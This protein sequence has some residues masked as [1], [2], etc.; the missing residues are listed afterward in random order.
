M[1]NF[2]YSVFIILVFFS[3]S[4]QPKI[5][6]PDITNYLI[7]LEPIIDSINTK[8]DIKYFTINEEN[9][10]LRIRIM[11]KENKLFGDTI[12][13]FGWRKNNQIYINYEKGD[14]QELKKLVDFVIDICLKNIYLSNI[15]NGP[16]ASSFSI[17][18]KNHIYTL[19]NE[20]VCSI[21]K[22]TA[23]FVGEVYYKDSIR[24]IYKY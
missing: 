13:V 19:R 16:F 12:C 15:T 14:N 24:V 18:Y 20:R 6:I 11:D 1:V 3:C 10:T 22:N 21:K 23:N 7:G 5:N 8:Y 17:N 9:N 2:I 4:E